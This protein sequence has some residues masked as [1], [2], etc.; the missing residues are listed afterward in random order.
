MKKITVIVGALCAIMPL[1]SALSASTDMKADPVAPE[2]ALS[3]AAMRG[4][5]MFFNSTFGGHK[6]I[7]GAAF[8]CAT[9]HAGDSGSGRWPTLVNAA[10]IFPSYN[11][12]AHK[13]ITLETQI[14][15]CVKGAIG[16][17]PFAYDSSDMVDLVAYLHLIAKGQPIDMGGQL[18]PVTNAAATDRGKQAF[19]TTCFG[20]HGTGVA[21]APKFGDNAAW[22]SHIAKGNS[23]LYTHAING[24][25][26]VAGFMPPKGGNPGL[27]DA[28]VKAAVDYMVEHSK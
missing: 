1:A 11:P 7:N 5:Q 13:V 14:L 6:L 28:D 25:Q 3:E 9:C 18:L 27:V 2:Q 12:T 16:G 23:T 24:F 15:R 26:G 10:A 8:T 19:D 17:E 21:G 22:K 4:R 20:C